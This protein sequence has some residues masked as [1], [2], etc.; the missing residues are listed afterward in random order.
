MFAQG[1]VSYFTTAHDIKAGYQFDYAW[2]EVLYFSSSGMRADYRSGVP[3]SVNTYNTPA[4]SIP[5]NIQQ[6]LYIQDKWRP[7]PQADDQWRPPSGHELRMDARALPGGDAVRR[8]ALLRQDV[9][10]SRLE[11]REPALL[12]G[13][14]HR[15]RRPHGAEVRGEPLHHSGR[16]QRARSRQPDLP[17]E[18]H[19][20]VARAVPRA[21]R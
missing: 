13:V 4:R 1:S 14:R 21:H 5:E 17:G 8:G 7:E 10:R 18:R 3:D 16:Q 6:G 9:G 12:G 20:A 11:S 19:A 2:N 15:R